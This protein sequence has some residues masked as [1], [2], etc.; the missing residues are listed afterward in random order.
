MLEKTQLAHGCIFSTFAFLS[1]REASGFTMK[2]HA[3]TVI[4]RVFSKVCKAYR[5][6]SFFGFRAIVSYIPTI[7]VEKE[8]IFQ[9]WVFGGKHFPLKHDSGRVSSRQLR[10]LKMIWFPIFVN[11]G[12]SSWCFRCVHPKVMIVFKTAPFP[13]GHFPVNQ[14]LNLRSRHW[15]DWDLCQMLHCR[16]GLK[17][18]NR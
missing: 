18:W 4:W 2:N 10:D 13:G 17:R 14:L 3:L 15:C 9:R 8:A 1:L 6:R 16:R 5:H 12:S 7:E 11:L